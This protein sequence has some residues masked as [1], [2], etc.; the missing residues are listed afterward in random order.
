M[1]DVKV[2]RFER[3]DCAPHE[4]EGA[5]SVPLRS[6]T[7]R[8]LEGKARSAHGLLLR[9]AVHHAT[10]LQHVL[11]VDAYRSA[12]RIEP[13]DDIECDGVH[14]VIVRRDKH[15]GIAHVV[16]DIRASEANALSPSGLYGKLGY[17]PELD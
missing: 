4:V 2:S 12:L 10:P 16:V 15:H 5:R 1:L 17:T 7:F 9:N 14:R 8:T 6:K 13:L 11:A 3:L